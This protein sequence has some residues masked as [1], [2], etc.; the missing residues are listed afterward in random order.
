MIT[1]IVLSLAAVACIGLGL[2]KWFRV[3]QREHYIPGSCLTT[4]RRWV[5]RRPPNLWIAVGAGVAVVAALILSIGEGPMEINV[6]VGLAAV[7]LL[8][9]LP[10]GLPVVGTPKLRQTGRMVRLEVAG[11]LI[12]LVLAALAALVVPMWT[13]LV[14]VA[15]LVP[16]VVDLGAAAVQPL[17]RRLLRT[18]VDRAESR[19]QSID[20]L[21]IAITGSYGKTTT[22]EHLRDL[23][24]AAGTRV[25]ASPA[26]YNN[27]AGLSLTVN[28]LMK[29]P[30]EVFVAE[31]GMYAKG[32]IR[33]LCRW[34]KPD[35]GVITSIGPVHL[36]RLGS[37]DAIVEA[38]AEILETVDHAVLWIGSPELNR[39]ADDLGRTRPEV[40][41]W[42]VGPYNQGLD[43]LAVAVDDQAVEGEVLIRGA[44]GAE[45][46]RLVASGGLIAQNVACAVAACLAAGLP[47]AQLSR[48]IGTL[49][50][51]KHRAV[52]EQV[53]AGYWVI[54]DT[55]NSNPAGAARA[56]AQLE[57]L[58][59]D[60]RI[61]VTPGMVELGAEQ[62]ERNRELA[63][64]VVSRG[65]ELVIV[66]HTNRADLER[67]AASGDSVTVENRQAASEHVRATTGSSTAVLWENDLPDHY[68]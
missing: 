2:F 47:A 43:G 65:W 50:P 1:D 64:S 66:G 44:D 51:P 28:E 16:A 39:L 14:L 11:V 37:I 63:E 17:E 55:F 34:V 59:V 61:V 45:L 38:K 9:V 3:S 25:I 68:P 60:R 32:E 10:V 19:L 26:S 56:L 5:T 18:F 62:A 36:E 21:T 35:I 42:R 46:T 57:D 22:K 24:S 40:Q 30:P 27:A 4:L 33:S 58:D 6:L 41:L 52:A 15:A 20:P 23:L 8:A 13:A 29:D 12:A 49:K 53:D 7:A 31:M 67:G 54:D 48:G